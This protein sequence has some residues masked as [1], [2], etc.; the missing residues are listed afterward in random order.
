MEAATAAA[1]PES[2]PHTSDGVLS[3]GSVF[4]S[5]QP[6]V[7]VV[8]GF[9][10][11]RPWKTV[12]TSLSSPRP[13]HG[14]SMSCWSSPSGPMTAVDLLLLNGSLPSFLS[15]TIERPDA[16]RAAATASGRSW[17]ASAFAGST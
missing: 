17:A 15:S 13:H 5:V 7:N 3:G 9:C 6:A 8:F 14:P 10:F 1:K 2:S 12:T 11:L 4:L 16:L